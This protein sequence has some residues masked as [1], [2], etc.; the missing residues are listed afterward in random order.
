MPS[1]N[2]YLEIFECF[3][4]QQKVKDAIQAQ[5]RA[6]MANMGAFIRKVA[7]QSMRRRKK[8]SAPGQ[9]P[10]AHAGQLRDLLF[11][12]Y[13]ENSDTTVIGPVKFAGK[14]GDANVPG[15]M[16]FGG[17]QN[18]SLRTPPLHAAGAGARRGGVAALLGQLGKWRFGVGLARHTTRTSGACATYTTLICHAF[19]SGRV[20]YHAGI[21]KIA[22][23]GWI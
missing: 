4:D 7:R 13:D 8:S 15:L 17:T 3:F 6:A 20:Q 11:F 10:S 1:F 9:P 22:A 18:K 14:S 16:E 23:I 21:R 5:R 19:I 12:S 2:I